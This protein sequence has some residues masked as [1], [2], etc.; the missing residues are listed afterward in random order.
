MAFSTFITVQICFLLVS[1]F[2]VNFF[3]KS[4]NN[5]EI[6]T[7]YVFGTLTKYVTIFMFKCLFSTFS[8]T[9]KKKAL[10]MTQEK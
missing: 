6:T 1:T 5:F 10:K 7:T 8:E 3:F 9:L 2:R 4:F